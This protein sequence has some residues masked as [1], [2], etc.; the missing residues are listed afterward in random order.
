MNTKSK[1]LLLIGL[2]AAVLAARHFG[3]FD[4]L[5]LQQFQQQRQA[6]EG[7]QAEH[8]LLMAGIFFAVYVA[9]TA[10]SLPG[11]AVM[12]LVGGA[13]FGLSTGLLLVSF[14]SSLGATLA[15]LLARLLLR[16]W[17]QSKFSDQLQTINE[18]VA[19]DGK[20][21]LFSLRLVPVV[22]F[23]VINVVMALTPMRAWPFY[24][25]SQL[26][27]LPGTLVYV[28]AG[29]QLGQ[30]D[31]AGGILNPALIASFVLLAAFPWVVKGVS[32]WID[33]RR[34]AGSV[35]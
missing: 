25:V 4:Y 28:N 15:F 32:K 18:G 31:S 20:Y 34:E 1:I 9:V 22:P 29:T 3:L 14:A 24:W 21:Y 12:T 19:K 16:D 17:V 2:V 26:G 33:S 30:L 6:L 23:F 7:W 10:L 27:M 11:A 5:S 8:P 35:K 13:L